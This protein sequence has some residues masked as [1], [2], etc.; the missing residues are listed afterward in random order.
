V[1]PLEVLVPVTVAIGVPAWAAFAPTS[2]LFGPTVCHVPRG[3][4]LTF[5]DG[6]NPS[7]TPRLLALL[8]RHQVKATFFL[9][10]KYVAESP[11]LTAEIAAAGHGIGNHTYSHP[12]LIFYSRTRIADEL[13]RCDT[14]IFHATDRRTAFIR[15]PFGFR[16]PLFHSAARKAGLSKVVMWSVSGRDWTPQPADRV[17]RRL[18]RARSGDIVLLHDG[19]HRQPNADRS[20]MLQALEYW[21]P[22]WK[23]SGLE[24]S[25]M[26]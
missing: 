19:D 14:A 1:D 20:H 5:D 17:Q 13:N 18:S 25:K 4:A 15:P 2:Q 26:E 21:L 16:G 12:S 6:P 3:C 8:E 23:D 7:V 22:R 24:F 11:S 9:L 10:G